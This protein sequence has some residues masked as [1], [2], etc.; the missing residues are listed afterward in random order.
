MQGRTWGEN[1]NI[2]GI[3]QMQSGIS[4]ERQ[5]NNIY[6][7]KVYTYKLKHGLVLQ[8]VVQWSWVWNFKM[9]FTRMASCWGFDE[10]RVS[11]YFVQQFQ[12]FY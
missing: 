1:V 5:E 8:Y 12:H 4:I 2:W 7:M 6:L 9:N 10:N 11:W 3:K